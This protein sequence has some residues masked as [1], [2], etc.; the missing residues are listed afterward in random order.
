MECG[1]VGVHTRA[2]AAALQAPRSDEP[3]AATGSTTSRLGFTM[4]KTLAL[5]GAL[6]ASATLTMA[7]IPAVAQQFTVT[8]LV[9]DDALAHPAQLIDGGLV[10]AW[11]LSYTPT[12]PFWISSNGAGTSTLYK[13]DGATQAT[14]KLGL[15]V[16]IP[17]S[18]RVTGQVFNGNAASGAFNGDAFLFVSE[19]GTVSGWRAALGTTA[20]R[21][22]TPSPANVY[23]GVAFADVAGNSYL[24]AANFRAGSV[25]VMKGNAGAPDLTGRFLDPNLPAGFAPFNVQRLGDSIY[26][27]FAKQDATL[28]DEVA[29]AGLGFVDRFDLQ[30]NLV[31]RVASGGTLD[32]PWGL[33]IAPASFGS[34][35]GALLVG[36]FGDGRINAYDAATNT[37]I[38]QVAGPDGLALSIDG[39]WALSPGNDGSA[40]SSALLYFTAGPDDERHGLFGVL[41][42]VPEP[43]TWALLLA[44]LG[45]LAALRQ[46]RRSL[47]STSK[48]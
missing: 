8:P 14:A 1:A 42:A 27:A 12:G 35:A 22:A 17:D 10:N 15:T 40:G 45:P 2:D 23:K 39:L 38:G 25:D 47:R 7:A 20:E 48:P 31:S 3:A 26:V 18:G 30:G 43:S 34:W 33:A 6:A 32:A 21:L 29:G 44:G 9:S 5:L 46:R 13:V 37:L 24:Y 28:S 16:T 11:G 4:H 36:N 19:D 41:G